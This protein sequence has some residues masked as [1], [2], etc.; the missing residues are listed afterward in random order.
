MNSK[1]IL[2]AVL[3]LLLFSSCKKTI[4][5]EREKSLFINPVF[6][7]DISLDTIHRLED[8]IIVFDRIYCE[9]KSA[10]KWPVLYFDMEQK[11]WV[12]PKTGKNII[13]LGIEPS[14]CPDMM[15]E[16]DYSR[17]LE[18]VK[19]GYNLEVEEVRVEPDSLTSYISKQYLNYGKDPVYSASPADN[20]IWLITN[21]DDKLTNLNKYIAQIIDGYVIMARQY[22]LIHYQKSLDDLTDTEFQELKT[23]LAFHLSFKYSDKPPQIINGLML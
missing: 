22:S 18:V 19:D 16:Y 2:I 10:D 21:K 14:P 8:L 20:G 7:N 15:F 6:G 4:Y 9:D 23:T 3:A 1:I 13:A 17:I 5:S 12:N 11:E